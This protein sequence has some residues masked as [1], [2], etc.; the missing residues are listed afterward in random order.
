MADIALYEVYF[1]SIDNPT[2]MDF[3]LYKCYKLNSKGILKNRLNK[4]IFYLEKKKY[5]EHKEKLIEH[6]DIDIQTMTN[7]G[8]RSSYDFWRTKPY[9]IYIL[10]LDNGYELKCADNH[11]V[12]A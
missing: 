10:K 7:K 6:Q 5:G 9:N 4:I 2:L 3:I 11:L 8:F 12:Y 1:N